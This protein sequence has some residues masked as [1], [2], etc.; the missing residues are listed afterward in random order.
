MSDRTKLILVY[1][2]QIILACTLMLHWFAWHPWGRAGKNP[3]DPWPAYRHGGF[4]DNLD[5]HAIQLALIG[6]CLWTERLKLRISRRMN[7]PQ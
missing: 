1:A 7:K 5:D 4:K 2:A 6:G 3:G